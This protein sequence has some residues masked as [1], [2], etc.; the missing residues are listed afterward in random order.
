MTIRW[1]EQENG[2]WHG[3]SGELIVA[4]VVPDRGGLASAENA[5]PA[6]EKAKLPARKANPKRWLWE[7]TVQRPPGWRNEGHRTSALAARRAADDYWTRWCEAGAL[8][9][10]IE[11]LVTGSEAA[12]RTPARKR[13]AKA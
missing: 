11:R 12:P 3:L 6:S 5:T 1:E 7:V 13:R 8:K 4:L 9:P 10:D 2:D